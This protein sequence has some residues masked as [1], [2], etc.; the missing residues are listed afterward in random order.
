M[1]SEV[2]INFLTMWGGL[3]GSTMPVLLAN[4]E[5]IS[6]TGMIAIGAGLTGVGMVGASVGQGMA[7]YGACL[8]IGRN[9]EVSGKITTTLIITAAFCESGSIYSLLIALLLLFTL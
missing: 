1:Y 9:P 2:L 7:G 8:A 5:T 3:L 6:D 4:T